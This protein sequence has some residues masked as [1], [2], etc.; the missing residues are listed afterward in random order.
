MLTQVF[1]RMIVPSN[2]NG[3]FRAIAEGCAT[4]NGRRW[5]GFTAISN[6]SFL[7]EVGLNM[8]VKWNEPLE[9]VCE[10]KDVAYIYIFIFIYLYKYIVCI[11]IYI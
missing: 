9:T 6:K 11:Y 8:P 5:M 2:S 3:D 7:L 4:P 10:T 1:V